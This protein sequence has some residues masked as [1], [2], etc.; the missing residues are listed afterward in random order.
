M[1]KLCGATPVLVT[2]DMQSGFKITPQQLNAKITPK[3]RWFILNSPGNP[4]GAAYSRA[5][6]KALSQILLD[7]PNV[8]VLT[9]DI[10]EHL[11]YD[12]FKFSTLAQVEPGLLDRVLTM[13]GVSKAYAMTGWRIGYAGGPKWV[14]EAMAKVMS[15]STSNPSSISQWAA[16]EALN[17]PQDF[18]LSRNTAFQKRRNAIVAGLNATKGL[19]CA[20]PQG[21][22]YVYPSCMDVL[23]KT[24]PGGYKINSDLDFCQSLLEEALVAT[25]P[26]TAFHG[27]GHF[28]VSYAT[29]IK[30]LTRAYER[31]Q[32]FCEACR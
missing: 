31:I 29:D 14:I 32:T 30:S 25:V 5:E 3:T 2:C 4:T 27:V 19:S 18:L 17:G 23:G 10:Y 8:M 26:G 6:L 21:A 12:G 28:R 1:V 15:Q 22:F 13:N 24:S 16:V 20:T 7:H 9:D 11:V